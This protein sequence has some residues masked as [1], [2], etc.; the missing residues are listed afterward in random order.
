MNFVPT[1]SALV[2]RVTGDGRLP[3]LSGT[4]GRSANQALSLLQP[5]RFRS[6]FREVAYSRGKL[7]VEMNLQNI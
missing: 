4:E 1:V 2:S 3:R 6:L 5:K 7:F